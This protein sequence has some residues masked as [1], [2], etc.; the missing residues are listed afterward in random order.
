MFLCAL[1][2][3]NV[4]SS[5]IFH[6]YICICIMYICMLCCAQS[7]SHVQL[8][9]TPWTVPARLFCPWIF[10]RQEY[11]SGLPCPTLGALATP[12]IKHRSP[13]LQ[14]DS[15]LNEPPG[16]PKTGVG[17]LSFLQ[18]IFPTQESNWGLLCCRFFTVRFS[19]TGKFFTI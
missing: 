17:S 7:L 16:K 12:G 3:K 4:K 9:A 11:W 8:F 15:L 13:G 5:D 14:E 2:T 1:I 6:I 10:S 19:F 18:R